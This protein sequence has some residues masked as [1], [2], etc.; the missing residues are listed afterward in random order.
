M[1]GPI[2]DQNMENQTPAPQTQPQPTP[3]PGAIPQDSKNMAMLCHLLGLFTCFVGPLILW[4]IKKDEDKFVDS[5][6]KEALN[7]QITV[8]IGYVASVILSAVCIGFILMAAV[9]I[10]DLIFCIL[11]CVAASKGQDYRY[12]VC[13]RLVK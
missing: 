5:Q 8:T 12:P 10:C 11:A 2:M 1:E 7:F 6:G 9:G 13:L 3:E 4:L